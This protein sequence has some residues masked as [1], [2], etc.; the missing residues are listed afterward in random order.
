M[1]A[2]NVACKNGHMQRLPEEEAFGDTFLK[3]PPTRPELNLA[4]AADGTPLDY[5]FGMSAEMAMFPYLFP[6]GVGA[7]RAFYAMSQPRASSTHTPT[8]VTVQDDDAPA[9]LA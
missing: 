9:T 6:F 3:A 2:Y 5:Q 1:K 8:A 7:A 4:V